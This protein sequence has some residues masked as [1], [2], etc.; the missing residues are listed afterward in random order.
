[1]DNKDFPFILKENTPVYT[2]PGGKKKAFTE[3]KDS[4]LYVYSVYRKSDKKLYLKV[5]NEAGQEG[6]IDPLKVPTMPDGTQHT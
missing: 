5:K 4:W 2:T 1:M 6:Y 3:K